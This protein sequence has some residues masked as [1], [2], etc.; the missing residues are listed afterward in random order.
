MVIIILQQTIFKLVMSIKLSIIT[1]LM[2]LKG[3]GHFYTTVIVL[4]TMRL[5]VLLNMEIKML[6]LSLI[7]L[8]MQELN[9]LD[10]F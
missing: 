9:I 3:Y 10:L 7:K 4:M 8:Y 1:I 5:L 2:I 6:K